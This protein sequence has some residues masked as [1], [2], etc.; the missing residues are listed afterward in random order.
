MY[1]K[2]ALVSARGCVCC[3]GVT[4]PIINEVYAAFLTY[5]YH[6]CFFFSSPLVLSLCFCNSVFFLSEHFRFFTLGTSILWI[7]TVTGCL[8]DPLMCGNQ[9]TYRSIN[10]PVSQHR[11]GTCRQGAL[12]ENM[13]S[14]LF[15]SVLFCPP[16]I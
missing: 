13:M 14:V 6:L 4:H 15:R 7:M 1:T 3:S 16:I 5:I 2:R 9:A 12:P 8:R 10:S 11:Q